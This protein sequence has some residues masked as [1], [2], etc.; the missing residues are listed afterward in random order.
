VLI[1]IEIDRR[2]KII[3]IL[4]QYKEI[5]II[6]KARIK[7]N[8]RIIDKYICRFIKI[9]EIEIIIITINNIIKCNI[10]KIS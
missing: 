5:A 8:N 7:I 4:S 3:A 2:I 10:G 6:N 1:D 9:T